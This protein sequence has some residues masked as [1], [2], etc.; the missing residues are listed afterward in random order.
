MTGEVSVLALQSYGL[1]MLYALAAASVG[2][3]VGTFMKGTTGALVLT[4]F[5]LFL[6]LPTVDQ[7]VGMI[8]GIRPEA[9]LTFQAGTIDY[10][11]ITPYPQDSEMSFDIGTGENFTIYTLIPHVGTAIVVMAGYVLVCNALAMWRFRRREMLG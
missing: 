3:L 10:I 11:L 2:Y 6:I 1:A 9:S 8:A 4:F 5:L 7:T